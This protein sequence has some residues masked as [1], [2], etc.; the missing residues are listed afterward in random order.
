LT[1]VQLKYALALAKTGSFARAAD[2]LAIAQP[3][4]SLQ[5]QKLERELGIVLFDRARHPVEPTPGG[6][7]FLLQAQKVHVEAQKLEYLFQDE[8]TALSGE[9][10]L[11][12]IPT[13]AGFILPRLLPAMQARYPDLR[14]RVFEL[15]TSQILQKLKAD[16]LDVGVAA[17]PI[18]DP[19]INE[20][21]MYY[22]PFK[23]YLPPSAKIKKSPIRL[24]D[25][26]TL[27]MIVLGEDHCFR[28]QVS[29]IC[30]SNKGSRI[31][32]GSFETIRKLV[33]Q[34]LGVTLLPYGEESG[35]KE[36]ER[37]LASPVPAREISLVT[38]D[39]FYRTGILSAL[40]KEIYRFTPDDFK[41]KKA[42]R[43]VGV[44]IAQS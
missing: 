31:E 18:G 42:Y 26:G 35:N 41:R 2:L 27:E 14:L 8:K 6:A 32:A 38:H 22:E 39:S 37:F 10:R 24:E 15:P 44:E 33:D 5:I 1:L 21:P 20:I 11:G 3:T 29:H 13:V 40:Q 4:L 34:D 23:V 7:R 30:K 25:I 43:I 36:R 16:D 19:R 17:T 9:L 12:V 28:G